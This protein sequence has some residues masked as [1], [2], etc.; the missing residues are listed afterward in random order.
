MRH[1]FLLT[2]L[3][4]LAAVLVVFAGRD[5][6]QILGVARD[7]SKREIKKQY[8]AL[9]KQYH[10]DKNPGNKEAEEKFV[11]LAEGKWAGHGENQGIDGLGLR[12][13][14]LNLSFV[15]ELAASK[16]SA[17]SKQASKQLDLK[18]LL[19]ISSC[20]FIPDHL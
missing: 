2:L 1:S 10:P 9:S 15:L 17:R 19:T 11:K 8:K 13:T 3:A 16:P 5:Y 7:A 20:Y 18:R 4:L 6:Y 12:S 14:I